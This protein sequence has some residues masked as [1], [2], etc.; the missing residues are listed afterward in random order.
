MGQKLRNRKLQILIT[1]LY[2]MNLLYDQTS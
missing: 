1:V 2:R